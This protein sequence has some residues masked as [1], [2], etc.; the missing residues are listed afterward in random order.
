MPFKMLYF[1]IKKF[2]W[3]KQTYVWFANH[4]SDQSGTW[5]KPEFQIGISVVKSII[6]IEILYIY[7][8]IYVYTHFCTLYFFSID[9]PEATVLAS[10]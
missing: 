1:T 10:G 6:Y 8:Y 7:I 2:K 4:G 9:V 5:T 3:N